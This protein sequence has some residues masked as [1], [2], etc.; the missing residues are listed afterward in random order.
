[1]EVIL[2]D[3]EAGIFVTLLDAK[4]RAIAK[5]DATLKAALEL[6]GKAHG[7]PAHAKIQVKSGPRL[8]QLRLCEVK[9]EG[10]KELPSTSKEVPSA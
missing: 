4:Q 9:T 1:M 8:N 10:P 3:A 6:L 5:H 7:F 2:S